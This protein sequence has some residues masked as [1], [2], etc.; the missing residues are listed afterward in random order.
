MN[1]IRRFV[2]LAALGFGGLASAQTCDFTLC[3]T[4]WEYRVGGTDAAGPYG[5]CH[6]CDWWGYCSHSL[7]HCPAGSTL[8]ATTGVCTWN[9]CLG[10]CGGEL[11]LCEADET[12]TGWGRDST[13]L[14]GDCRRG[15]T[16]PGGY[17]SHTPK[18]CRAGWSLQTATGKCLKQCLADL[19]VKYAYLKDAS[20]SVVSSVR[21]GRPYYVCAD[22]QNIGS[23][24]SGSSVLGGGGLGV[25]VAPSVMVPGIGPTGSV[26]RCLYYASAPA[27][28]TWRIGVTADSTGV[29]PENN[30]G[31]NGYTVTVV[32]TP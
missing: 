9:L 14:Y 17:Y 32:V 4:G 20:G 31:N 27:P 5:S 6:H 11:P 29:V 23:A 13:G 25:P 28:G 3:R 1:L 12:Y 8:N 15:P 19:I 21:A 18:H 10:G 22:V 16:P 26:T 30:D 24:W 7:E 2:V